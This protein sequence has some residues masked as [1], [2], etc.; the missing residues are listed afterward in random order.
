MEFVRR[1][2][3]LQINASAYLPSIDTWWSRLDE[4]FRRW[5]VNN[6]W[7]PLAPYTLGEIERVGGPGADD[8]Y[9]A[10]DNGGVLLPSEAIRWLVGQPDF[11]RLTMPK[12]P[13]PRAAVLPPRMAQTPTVTA[14]KTSLGFSLVAPWAEI[15]SRAT[16]L[17]GS[18]RGVQNPRSL[19][20]ISHRHTVCTGSPTCSLPR[21][22]FEV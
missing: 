9:W 4:Q 14:G 7:S 20:V 8:D 18:I 1:C 12:Q 5:I 11:E 22:C 3:F 19:S 13:D 15:C 21:S 6:L 10:R 2:V 16:G 17:A